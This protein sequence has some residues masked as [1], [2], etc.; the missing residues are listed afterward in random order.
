METSY[1]PGTG[2]DISRLTLGTMTFGGQVN[3]RDSFHI[4]DYA[5]DHGI[6][7]FDT[8]NSYVDGESE[9]IVGQWLKGRRERIILATKAHKHMPDDPRTG[10]LSRRS[11]VASCEGSLKRLNTDYIDIYYM[12][13]PDNRTSLE[14]SLEAMNRLVDEGKVLYVGMSNHAAWQLADSL[15]ICDRRGY[16]PPIVT[17]VVYNLLTRSLEAELSPFLAA[18]QMGMVIYNPIAGGLLSGK[19]QPGTP[20]KNTR[21]GLKAGYLPRYWLDENFAAIEELDVIARDHGLNLLQ[22]ALRWCASRENVT[23]ILTGV[24]N[25][26]QLEQNIAAI[27]AGTLSGDIMAQ[28]D[29]VWASLAGTRYHYAR[30]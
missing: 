16:L 9:R 24:S 18:H 23:S 22:L 5:I 28:C 3:H 7:S 27:E 12:H 14:E 15:A 4:M 20:D 11:L 26:S 13:H 8:A 21:F 19:H 25:L 17:Q 29:D 2:I 6:N 10:G 1:F 30:H